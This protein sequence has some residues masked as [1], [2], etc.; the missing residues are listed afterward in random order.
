M[1]RNSDTTC[2]ECAHFDIWPFSPTWSVDTPGEMFRIECRE[3]LWVFDP[4]S[5]ESYRICMK[6]AAECG[7]F[8]R[9]EP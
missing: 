7:Q 6:S 9:R 5:A 3:K 4:E 8:E 2:I 1:E